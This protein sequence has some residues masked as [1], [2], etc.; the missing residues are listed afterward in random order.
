MRSAQTDPIDFLALHPLQN[1]LNS[2]GTLEPGQ[3]LSVI[4]PFVVDSGENGHSYRAV[5]TN[6]RVN[7]LVKLAEQIRDIPDGMPI[8]FEVT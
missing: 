3:L 5:S 8:K 4:H 7:F 6:E 1:H 2:G